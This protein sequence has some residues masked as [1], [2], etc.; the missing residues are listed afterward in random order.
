M[1]ILDTNVLYYVL[2]FSVAPCDKQ[3]LD[4]FITRNKCCIAT[5]SLYEFITNPDNDAG[6]IRA[7]VSSTIGLTRLSSV[8]DPPLQTD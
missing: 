5:A 8:F 3:K 7:L 6:R 1:F 4:A 2:G